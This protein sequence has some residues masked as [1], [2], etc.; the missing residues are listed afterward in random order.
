M[1]T[2]ARF[3]GRGRSCGDIRF[4]HNEEDMFPGE[5]ITYK[6]SPEEMKKLLEGDKNVMGAAAKSKKDLTK[7]VYLKLVKQ[8]MIDSDIR[9]KYGI[10]NWTQLKRMKNAWGISGDSESKTTPKDKVLAGISPEQIMTRLDEMAAGQAEIKKQLN[11]ILEILTQLTKENK[12]NSQYSQNEN[13]KSNGDD[14]I[15]LIRKLL[16]ELL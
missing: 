12:P 13:E 10:S 15:V 4:P 11:G 3:V 9:R 6:L 7:D 16:K 5:V 8:G 14:S 1:V 2:R